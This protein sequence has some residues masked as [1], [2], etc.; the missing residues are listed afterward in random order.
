MKKY[1]IRFTK[2]AIKD[3]RKLSNR[4]TGKLHD[5]LLK[6]VAQNHKS[7]KRFVGELKG[8]FSIRLSYRDRIVYSQVM[9]KKTLSTYIEQEHTMGI[10]SSSDLQTGSI[11]TDQNTTIKDLPGR[12]SP[13]RGSVL[14]CSPVAP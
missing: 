9:M 5:F 10:S 14:H 4:E 3:I 13:S 12:N 7:G 11:V 8:F 6:R 2:E 1:E